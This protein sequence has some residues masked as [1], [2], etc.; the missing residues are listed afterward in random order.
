MNGHKAPRPKLVSALVGNWVGIFGLVVAMCSLFAALCLIAIDFF[1]GF[2]QPYMGILIFLIVPSFIWIGLIFA[3]VGLWLELRRRKKLTAAEA[4][5][6]ASGG[7]RTRHLVAALACAFLFVML[8]SLGSYR[9]FE[10]TESPGFCGALCHTVMKPEYTTYKIS[11]HSRVRCTECHIGPGASWF[12]RSK[13]SGLYQVYATVTDIYPRPIPVPVQN[14]RPAQE[15]CEQCHWPAK[16][17]GWVELRRQFF[18]PDKQNTPWNIRLL[19]YVGGA[20][21]TKGPVEGIHWHMNVGNRME[22]IATDESRQTIPWV[23]VTNRKTGAVKVYQSQNNP[24]TPQQKNLPVRVLDCVD[25][26]NRPT[27]IFDSPYRGLDLSMWLGRIDPSIPYVKKKAAEALV[28]AAGTVSQAGGIALIAQELSKEFSDYQDQPKIGQA[29]SETQRIFQDN[30]FPEMKTDWKV[31]PNNIGHY[32]WPGCF[33]CHDGSH[34]DET[35]RA[36]SN[37]C[38]TCHIIT[39]QGRQ[40][41]PETVSLQGLKF[42]HPGGEIPP[43]ILCSECHTGAP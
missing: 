19:V 4:R 11:P 30:F 38:N 10:V 5:V 7:R 32:I 36:I 31:R 8:T 33:R 34:V 39:S 43:E 29:I 42:D 40:P 20:D 41:K 2:R 3:G 15:T 16:F 9:A 18:L 26:H 6:E 24:L 1:T 23:R 21:A 17:F 13:I 14:L 12:V 35:G 25:C 22:Y 28:K 37:A 27:H